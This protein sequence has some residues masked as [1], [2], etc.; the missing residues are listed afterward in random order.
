MPVAEPVP[1]GPGDRRP[2][3][4][5]RRGLARGRRGD[6][7]LVPVSVGSHADLDSA[8]PRSRQHHLVLGLTTCQ[9]SDVCGPVRRWR[10]R[11]RT[12]TA[13]SIRASARASL[14]G[15][16]RLESHSLDRFAAGSNGRQRQAAAF[17]PDRRR[18]SCPR[19][20]LCERREPESLRAIAREREIVH[21]HGHW[22]RAST[23][24]RP[25][26]DRKR[27]PRVARRDRRPAVRD[28]VARDHEACAPG[29]H[30]AAGRRAYQLASAGV[31]RPARR[32]SPAARSVSRRFCARCD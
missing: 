6:A 7:C 28:A 15:C 8:R 29:R 23:H 3:H 17:D 1:S 32:T 26:A 11:S 14:G 18:R 16:R 9:S 5:A 10:A 21:P 22:R 24:R 20:R 12:Y 27:R 30:A 25:T 31:H 19:D 13:L 2:F 4:P